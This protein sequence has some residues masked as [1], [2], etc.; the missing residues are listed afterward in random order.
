MPMQNN[1]TIYNV[2]RKRELVPLKRAYMECI[3]RRAVADQV[4]PYQYNV[5]GGSW[6]WLH[7][8]RFSFTITQVK[9][10]IRSDTTCHPI[11]WTPKRKK[12]LEFLE[13][14]GQLFQDL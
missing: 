5:Y 12:D 9:F 8:Y 4:S 6:I 13:H 7:V 14:M 3:L 10:W 2:Y 1:W 11:F